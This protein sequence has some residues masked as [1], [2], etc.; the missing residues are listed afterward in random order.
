MPRKKTPR[1]TTKS[2]PKGELRFGRF[3][4]LATRKRIFERGDFVIEALETTHVQEMAITLEGASAAVRRRL[5]AASP[6]GRWNI[7]LAVE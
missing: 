7:S 1:F 4:F 2:S 3:L 6:E 5:L